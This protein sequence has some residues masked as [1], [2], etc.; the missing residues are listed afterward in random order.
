[1]AASL[2][3]LDGA[4]IEFEVVNDVPAG[5][6]LLALPALL[7]NG[8]LQH[9]RE[10]F[11][12]PEGFYP[13]ES[14]FLLLALMALGRIESA[15]Q[16]RYVAPGEWGK[17]LGLDRIPEVRT[18]RQKVAA[19]CSEEGRAARWSSVLAKD[20]MEA[21]PASA[22]V[23]YVD[24]HVRVYHGTLTDLPRRYIARQRLCL[25]GTTDYWVNAMD[26]RP[27]FCITQ[28]VDPGLGEVLRQGLAARL[29]EDV[30]G[31]SGAATLAAD[32]L[33]SRLTIVFDRGGYSPELFAWLWELR[34]AILTYHKFP[35]APWPKEEFSAQEV[36][37]ING[38]KVT[39]LL[40]ERGTRLTNGL[41][42][43]EV[44]RLN[45]GDHQT[46]ILSTDYYSPLTRLAVAM[47]ARWCQENFFR[48]MMEH[49]GLDRLVEHGVQPLPDTTR[50]VDPTWRDL[51]SQVRRQ[52]AVLSQQARKLASLPL[53]ADLEPRKIEAAERQ[54][55]ELQ[56]AIEH[57]REKIA[58]LKV[59]RKACSKH[60][61]LKDL[62]EKD[63]FSQL[64]VERKHF[65]DTIKLVAYRAETALAHIAR[66]KMAR[67]DDARSLL[68]QVFSTEADLLPDHSNHTLTVRLHP[69]TA[70][71][72]DQILSHL[73]HQLNDTE[74]IFPGTDL[75][76]VYEI[77]SST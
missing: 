3:T 70:P 54:R 35:E 16:L 9:S 66:E 61:T 43:R 11:A 19:L 64:R 32:P 63:R 10:I 27:F 50:V 17:L 12:M 51:D 15:E 6:V 74:T 24:A 13:L 52:N 47:F 31:Q 37:L 48:Y 30:P 55:G 34:I 59:Q 45:E 21:E 20:W 71:A 14:I 23:L 46:A 22:G 57:T 76:L 53:P 33:L 75:R 1:L 42:V 39:M 5:G 62:P 68:R 58:L 73:C 7:Q 18:L 72:H 28:A 29:L 69:L 67:L 60:V 77:I 49:Y 38:E 8:L 26:G 40:A 65:V 25:R 41:W 36:T 56:Q 2:G 44:R 4:P